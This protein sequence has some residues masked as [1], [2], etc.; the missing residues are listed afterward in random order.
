MLSQE[1]RPGRQDKRVDRMQKRIEPRRTGKKTGKRSGGRGERRRLVQLLV[2]AGLFAVVLAGKGL[3]PEKLAESGQSLLQMIQTDAD[4]QSAFASLGESM[5]QGESILES[6]GELAIQVFGAQQVEPSVLSTKG[7]AVEETMAYMSGQANPQAALDRVGG[8]AAGEDGAEEEQTDLPE[9][10]SLDYVELDLGETATPVLGVVSS[11][12]GY[13]EDP[14][15]GTEQFHNGVD[16]AAEEGTSI[17]AFADGTVE[18]TGQDDTSGLYLQLEHENQVETFYCHCSALYVQT[19]DKVE[20]GQAIAAVGQTGNAT[21]P[22]LHFA[23][24][25]CGVLLDPVYYIATGC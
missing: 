1:K 16:I 22:H 25:C 12:F 9:G 14:I 11:P 21:G 13:R 6:L 20:K 2:C 10:T 19:G 5:S 18:F 3:A 17:L 4:F 23:I 24:R 7:L 8:Q 15:T